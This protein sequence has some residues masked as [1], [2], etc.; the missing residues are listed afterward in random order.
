M[1]VGLRIIWKYGAFSGIAF[2]KQSVLC[3][4]GQ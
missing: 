2:K 4:I 1:G 3:S